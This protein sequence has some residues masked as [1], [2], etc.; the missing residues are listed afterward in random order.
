MRN[1]RR[2]VQECPGMIDKS[3]MLVTVIALVAVSL[4]AEAQSAGPVRTIGIIGHTQTAA[5]EEGLRELGWV[6]GKNVRFERR[7]TTDASKLGQFAAELVRMRVDV[8]FAGNAAATRAVVGATAAIPIITVSADPVS[9]GVASSLA[10]PGANVTGFAITQLMGK[11][12]DILVQA[13]PRAR[14]VALLVNPTNPNAPTYRR[15]TEAVAHTI[16]VK[17]IVFEVSAAERIADVVAAVAKARPD[18][19]VAAGDPLFWVA[20]QQLLEE[21]ARHRLPTMWEQLTFVEAGGLM[22]YGANPGDLYRRAATYADRILKGT[23]PADLPIDQATKFELAIN[24]KTARTLNIT[25]SPSMLIRA[26]NV[27]Q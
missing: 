7:V 3:L 21:V 17:L 9:A 19:F 25:I 5:F 4:A 26:D 20:R 18:A 23:K 1:R 22:S 14:R 13:L 8:I 15:D 11:R 10:R 24:L 6:E 16:G 27:I 2:F 12:L